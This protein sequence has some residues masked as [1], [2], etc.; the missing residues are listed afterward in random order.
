MIAEAVGAY[1]EWIT[2]QINF[3]RTSLLCVCSAF[4]TEGKLYLILDFLRGGDLFTRLS[5]EVY[6]TQYPSAISYSLSTLFTPSLWCSGDVHRRR[7]EVLSGWTGTGSRSPARSRHHLQRSQTWEVLIHTHT[8]TQNKVTEEMLDSV[9]TI[10]SVTYCQVWVW[11]SSD[12][13]FNVT[14]LQTRFL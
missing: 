5:K 8:H 14:H 7:C 3:K 9:H 2:D 4:Q 6:N 12:L 13:Y 10:H 1:H 11:Y